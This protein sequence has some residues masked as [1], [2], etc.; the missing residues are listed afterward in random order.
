MFKKK[1]EIVLFHLFSN[2]ILPLACFESKEVR[3]LASGSMWSHVGV[4]YA[5]IQLGQ[6]AKCGTQKTEIF[7]ESSG[8]EMLSY[9]S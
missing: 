9:D 3:G 2:G 6:K 7:C 5:H 8:Q 1:K 4:S